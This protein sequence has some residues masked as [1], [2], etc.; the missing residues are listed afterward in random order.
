MTK[1]TSKLFIVCAIGL[2]LVGF[3]RLKEGNSLGA[4]NTESTAIV[5]DDSCSSTQC[6][7]Q[8]S[9]HIYLGIQLNSP[10]MAQLSDR[11]YHQVTRRGGK[12]KR[13]TIDL[14]KGDR[15]NNLF[16]S[17]ASRKDLRKLRKHPDFDRDRQT[18]GLDPIPSDDEALIESFQRAKDLIV[19]NGGQGEFFAYIVTSGTTNPDTI[20]KIRYICQQLAAE[21]DKTGDY[22]LYVIGLDSSKRLST[23]SSL[24]PIAA[25]AVAANS[26][27]EWEDLIKRI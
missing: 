23:V 2:V 8:S 16:S 7:R 18:P 5:R 13:F 4:I 12:G 1:T 3:N 21:G 15:A 10:E 22:R 20:A 26:E 14:L 19:R 25:H 6:D 24:S 27:G 9:K 17:T 11:I